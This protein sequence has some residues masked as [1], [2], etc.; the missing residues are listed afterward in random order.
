MYVV[1]ISSCCHKFA[2]M[3]HFFGK[4]EYLGIVLYLGKRTGW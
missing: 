2:K 4:F 1:N 3:G